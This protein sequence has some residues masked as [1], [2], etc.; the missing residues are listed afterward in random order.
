METE[1]IKTR[2]VILKIGVKN[3]FDAYLVRN[4]VTVR[5]AR[6]EGS[7]VALL[8]PVD[9]LTRGWTRLLSFCSPVK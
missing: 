4:K 6:I 5:T 1:E 7:A 2:V 3:H 9:P 8:P